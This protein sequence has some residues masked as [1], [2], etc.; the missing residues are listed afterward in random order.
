MAMVFRHYLLFKNG[1]DEEDD[2]DVESQLATAAS[3][4]AFQ[5]GFMPAFTELIKR[6]QFIKIME[7][8]DRDRNID[9]NR[10]FI[11]GLD[12]ILNQLDRIT[13]K[14]EQKAK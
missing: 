5:S 8:L 7:C 6:E 14:A 3:N 13:M 9:F 11:A 2:F 4:L 10:G 1:W 12:R